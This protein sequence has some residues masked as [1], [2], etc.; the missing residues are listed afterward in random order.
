MNNFKYKFNQWRYQ[1]AQNLQ[2]FMVG[3][4]GL[5]DFYKFLNILTWFFII[6]SL[7]TR[8]GYFSLLAFVLIGYS[9]FRIFSKNY[10]KRYNE[11]QIY[12]KYSKGIRGFI[13]LQIRK[14]KER[15]NY[16]FRKCPNCKKVLRLPNKKGKHT[17]NCPNCYKPFE[18][19]I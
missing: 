16:R 13:K 18:V 19:R 10:P 12:L 8:K 1:Q 5:D 7:F 6:L 2:R 15:K 9:Y 17:V 14:F 11:N 3:R 4:Y